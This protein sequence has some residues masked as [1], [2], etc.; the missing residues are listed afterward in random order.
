MSTARILIAKPGLDGHDR[1]AK[2]VARLLR[3]A[4]YDV[5]YTGIRRSP[6]QIVAAAVQEDADAIG[7][8][9]HSGA[10]KFLF[11]RVI[12][13][14]HEQG[15]QD[16]LVFGGGTIPAKDIPLLQ[17]AGVSAVF[18][19]G[20]SAKAIVSGVEALLKERARECVG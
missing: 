13:L 1:G 5:I 7:L 12:D 16:M 8:S 6:E 20:T 14:L 2:F 9:V 18:T 3:D 17:Q 11:G 19:P 15:V 4:G 10:H